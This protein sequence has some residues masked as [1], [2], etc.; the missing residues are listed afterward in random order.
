MKK[1]SR[2]LNLNRETLIPLTADSLDGIHGGATPA[3]LT[4]TLTS[5]GSMPPSRPSICNPTHT[6]FFCQQS[7][8]PL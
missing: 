2:K 8:T 4:A 1:L 5:T 7:G 6:R 3:T